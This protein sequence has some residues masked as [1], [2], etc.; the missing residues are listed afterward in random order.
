[1]FFTYTFEDLF[2]SKFFENTNL[3]L[4]IEKLQT[5][6][7]YFE[8]NTRIL[9]CSNESRTKHLL[10]DFNNLYDSL[11]DTDINLKKSL[12]IIWI[13]Q[14]NKKIFYNNY[15]P[16][17]CSS[18]QDCSLEKNITTIKKKC[19]LFPH[20][21]LSNDSLQNYPNIT[22]NNYR[23][24]ELFNKFYNR[25]S[26]EEEILLDETK[27]IELIKKNWEALFLY[28]RNN[29]TIL[30]RNVFALWDN[31]YAGGIRQFSKTIMDINPQLHFNII[32]KKSNHKTHSTD[33]PKSQHDIKNEIQDTLNK[34]IPCKIE[35]TLCDSNSKFDH[36]RFIIFDNLFSAELSRG[37]DSF[38]ASPN[39][40]ADIIERYRIIYYDIKE[41]RN[42]LSDPLRNKTQDDDF[43]NLKNY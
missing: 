31:N 26:Y 22:V 2:F 13:D 12:E 21:I 4:C 8:K 39:P 7:N 20:F 43:K 25:T 18:L 37:L 1:M 23:N 34:L 40:R 32:T 35:V 19:K 16:C 11:L 33:K 28:C 3:E 41:V 36:D 9:D 15:T 6:F 30:D 27:G 38:Y 24:D 17:D 42:Y 5:L 10:N 14:I 29:I